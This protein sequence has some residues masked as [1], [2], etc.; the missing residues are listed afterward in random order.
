MAAPWSTTT[1]VPAAVREFYDK[2]LLERGKAVI[3]LEKFGQRRPIQ[4]KSGDKIKFRRYNAFAP[5]TTALTE[6]VPPTGKSLSVTDISATLAQY[7]DWT[8]ITDMVDF[9]NE[10][11]VLTEAT[12]VLGEQAGESIETIIRNILMGG[13]SVVFSGGTST[14]TVASAPTAANLKAIYRALK[15]NRG[16]TFTSLI[17]SGSGYGSSGIRPSYWIWTHPDLQASFEAL[18][19]WT[20]IEKYASMSDVMENEIGAISGFRVVVSDLCS[21]TANGGAAVGTTGCI[22]TG[23]SNIDVYKSLIFA[24]DAFGVCPLGGKNFETII[25]QGGGVTD[26]L[27]QTKAT[28]AWKATITACILNDNWMYRLESGA[29]A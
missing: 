10:D 11:P 17:K 8:K 23:G 14:A 20:P 2:N 16:K 6:G 4:M 24:R 28:V 12:D 13:T 25:Q 15:R 26:P 9:V 3:C 5:A 21:V 19:G 27:K 7:G 22:S 1:E 18:S 29:L